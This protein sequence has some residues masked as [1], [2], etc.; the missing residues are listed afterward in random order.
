MIER[1]PYIP[2]DDYEMGFNAR[3]YFSE[4]E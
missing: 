3:V 2:S 1:D 4:T